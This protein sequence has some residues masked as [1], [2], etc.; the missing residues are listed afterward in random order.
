MALRTYSVE[1][2]PSK[3]GPWVLKSE[4]YREIR[5]ERR[6]R[7]L[8]HADHALEKATDYKKIADMA[9]RHGFRSADRYR[10]LEAHM[11]RRY[12][13]CLEIADKLK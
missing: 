4:A 8:V 1:M 10:R 9:E 6:R 5:K 7:F 2:T 13:K 12:M 3:D 11:T